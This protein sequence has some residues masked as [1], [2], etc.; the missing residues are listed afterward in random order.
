MPGSLRELRQKSARMKIGDHVYLITDRRQ[1]GAG[2][3]AMICALQD[4]AIEVVVQ[5]AHG[6]TVFKVS[7]WEDILSPN[8][9]THSILNLV[10]QAYQEIEH[11]CGSILNLT[12]EEIVTR[13][14][15]RGLA[16]QTARR[17]V[18]LI[19]QAAWQRA[20]LPLRHWLESI[21]D[22]FYRSRPAEFPSPPTPRFA[23]P[24]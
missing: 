3:P 12:T 4:S 5:F 19:D 16:P 17:C 13:L 8:L 18:D 7:N 23:S 1:T 15:E 14:S 2:L 11:E 10:Y 24:A 21:R 20:Q 9:Y 22:F 6:T